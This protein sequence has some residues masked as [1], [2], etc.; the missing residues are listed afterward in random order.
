MAAFGGK[1]LLALPVCTVFQIQAGRVKQRAATKRGDIFYGTA[2][3]ASPIGVLSVAN[4]II[5][6]FYYS[7]RIKI[8]YI[9]KIQ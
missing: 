4:S 8:M 6:S 7:S 5:S 9:M 1:T 2:E 3:Y